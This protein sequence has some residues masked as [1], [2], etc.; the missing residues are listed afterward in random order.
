MPMEVFKKNNILLILVLCLSAL[1]CDNQEPR[2]KMNKEEK[3]LVDSLYSA[4]LR[5]I[6]KEMGYHCSDLRDSLFP[7][8]V[9]SIRELRLIEVDQIIN[10]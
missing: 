9:D 1:S 4:Q 2:N 5:A 8:Y 6:K 10:N 3:Q 7:I